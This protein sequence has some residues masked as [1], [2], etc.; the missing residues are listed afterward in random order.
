MKKVRTAIRDEQKG[1]IFI[2]VILVVVIALSIIFKFALK[3]DT[4]ADYM[5]DHEV[6]ETLF[7]VE[8]HDNNI[9]FSTLLFNH[10]SSYKAAMLNIPGFTGAIFKTIGRTDKIDNVYKEKGIEGYKKE[11]E[12]M[13]GLDVEIPFYT[14]IGIDDF[15]KLCDYI[16]GL[17]IFI[18]EPI[19]CVSPEGERW[20]LPS[21]AVTLDGDKIAVYLNYRE[22]SEDEFD[23]QERYQN[24]A[25]AFI[26]GIHNKKFEMFDGDNFK[27]YSDCIKSN[28]TDEE[29]KTLFKLI[30]EA[31]AESI[32]RQTITGSIR[33]VDDQELLI[34]DNNGE[35]IKQAV[36]QTINILTSADGN[37]SSRL[38]V[39]E[40]QNGTTKP[41]LAR[42][43]ATQ[44]TETR[45]YDV[46]APKNA[47]RQDYEK[48]VILDRKNSPEI[49]KIVGQF[50]NCDNIR[51]ITSEE[52]Q[53]EFY[54]DADID[55][56]II[57]GSDFDEQY[58]R[59][60]NK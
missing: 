47:R 16:G 48:T 8:D 42:K 37:L 44:Y 27:V 33:H 36:R 17:R 26:S 23:I 30:A 38:Y 32:I 5:D 46:L 51:E 40:I 58:G 11:L 14:V 1:I 19:D 53:D 43:T 31:D 35:F 34:P 56:T 25:A 55:F 9:L 24:C 50:I 10:S 57:L 4:V 20:L 2:A 22:E 3:T 54:S 45:N 39:L 13:L 12:K 59:V 29:E 18:S 6:V 15:T 28:I 60:I 52:E 41:G 7:I 49:A 21:G